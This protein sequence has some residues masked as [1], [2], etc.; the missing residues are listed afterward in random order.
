MTIV[1]YHY[2]RVIGQRKMNIHDD[3]NLLSLPFLVIVLAIVVGVFLVLSVNSMTTFTREGINFLIGSNWSPSSE[4]Y[5]ILPA[6][7]GT[8][9][10]SVIAVLLALPISLGLVAFTYEYMPITIRETIKSSLYYAAA[11]PTVVYGIWGLEFVVPAVRKFIEFWG[12]TASPTG[13]SILAGAIVLAFMNIPY[14][15]LIISE[16]YGKIPF[17]YIEAM[18]SLGALGY[19]RLRIKYGMVKGAVLGASLLVF[20]KCVGETTAVSMVVGNSFNLALSPLM[21]G[22]TISSLIVNYVSETSLYNYMTGAL[23]A[24]AL[25]MLV[26][27]SLFI[28]LGMWVARRLVIGG[29]EWGG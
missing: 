22:I 7:T 6:L 25:V 20:G 17:T 15:S 27:S 9:Y 2:I 29:G 23:F 21:P 19:E 11:I 10:T 1:L 5:Q 18:H 12:L 14:M 3:L 24:A 4:T 28:L 13:Q 16:V 26:S 8:F